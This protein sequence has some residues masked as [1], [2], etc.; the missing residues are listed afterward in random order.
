M[1][2]KDFLKGFDIIMIVM[3]IMII[4]SIVIIVMTKP[5]NKMN[6]SVLEDKNVL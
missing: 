3:I 5:A 6:N 1:N 2:Y 4:M